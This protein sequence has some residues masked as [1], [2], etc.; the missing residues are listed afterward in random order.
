MEA[1]VNNIDWTLILEGSFD[2]SFPQVLVDNPSN[3]QVHIQN[4]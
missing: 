2:D 1:S 3:E 4:S